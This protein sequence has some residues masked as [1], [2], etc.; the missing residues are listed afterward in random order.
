VF[1]KILYTTSNEKILPQNALFLFI[2]RAYILG[3][4]LISA[5]PETLVFEAPELLVKEYFS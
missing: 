4:T 3:W 1:G 2:P 5:H